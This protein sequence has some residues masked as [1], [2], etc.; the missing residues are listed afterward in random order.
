M[1]RKWSIAY[2]L[3]FILSAVV[4]TGCMSRFVSD[5][6]TSSEV[7]TGS[8]EP[9]GRYLIDKVPESITDYDYLLT[10]G[11]DGVTHTIYLIPD[12]VKVVASY[13]IY[14]TSVKVDE[15]DLTI[16]LQSGNCLVWSHSDVLFVSNNYVLE[17][18]AK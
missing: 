4:S 9:M 17:K 3:V 5:T 11:V 15:P 14:I 2:V 12:S 10:I 18:I 6:D 8:E 13:G 16:K 7:V 1:S